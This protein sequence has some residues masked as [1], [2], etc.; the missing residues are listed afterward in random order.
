MVL[1]LR[2]LAIIMIVIAFADPALKSSDSKTAQMTDGL[3]TVYID[4]SFSMMAEGENGRLFEEAIANARELVT[5]SS[6]DKRFVLL[7]NNISPVQRRVLSK[8]AML[9][10][11]EQLNISPVSRK[12]NTVANTASSIAAEKEYNNYEMYLFSDFQK[13]SIELQNFGRDTAAFFYLLP[14]KHLQKRNIYIDSC[15]LSDPVLITNRKITINVRIRNS[16]DVDYEKIPLKLW[17]NSQQK[18][19]AGIDIRA[20]GYEVVTMNYSARQTGWHYG[21]F[22]I[23]DYPITF[24]DKFYFSFN[25]KQQVNVLEIGT[26]GQSNDLELFYASDSLFY[27]EKMDYQRVKYNELNQ[28]KLIILNSL[29][30]IS[31]GLM[32]QMKEY[33]ATGGNLMFIPNTNEE[34]EEENQLLRLLGSGTIEKLDNNENRVVHIKNDHSLFRESVTDV[35]ENADLPVVFKH[36]RYRYGVGSGVESLVSLLNGDDFLLV[37]KIGNG[38]FY[39]LSVP[40]DNEFSN[41]TSHPLFVPVMYGVAIEGDAYTELFNIIGKNEKIILNSINS[42]PSNDQAYMVKK[43]EE[44]Y[45]FIPEQQIVNGGLIVDMHDG[46]ESDGFYELSLDNDAEHVFAF[47]F[48]RDE[49]HLDFYSADELNEQIESEALTHVKVL[50]IANAGYLELLNTVHKESQLWKLFIIFALLMLLSE[51]LVL[52]FWK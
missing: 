52:R 30:S 49:S 1:L 40:L 45:T 10:E 46:I 9:N 28:F 16:S 27:F 6:R 39:M 26:K 7:T 17:I 34:K 32:E 44:D 47:N 8:E 14:F 19:V 15:W 3:T 20:G 31:N 51:I 33:V 12:I 29:P 23:D 50:S 25:V 2:I 24:D 5:H 18:A 42:L 35:P 48:N 4:N 43:H 21:L 11:I 36:Y 41:F 37:T 13:N 38:R 22:E